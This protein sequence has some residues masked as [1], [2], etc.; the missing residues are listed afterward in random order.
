MVRTRASGCA[1]PGEGAQASRTLPRSLLLGRR[2]QGR[3]VGAVGTRKQ[4]S[5]S[6]LGPGLVPAAGPA[7]PSPREA[8]SS[9]RDRAGSESL[10]LGPESPPPPLAGA[11][12]GS[13]VV[14]CPRPP[15]TLLSQPACPQTLRSSRASTTPKPTS[16][17]SG[18]G[19]GAHRAC[20]ASS[21]P[22][23]MSGE[24]GPWNR[25]R[26]SGPGI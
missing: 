17:A 10:L 18:A 14:A 13:R 3:R 23:P 5:T 21:T 6:P 7:S 8:A 12:S 9:P 26:T 24:C 22:S 20:P 2:R 4:A 1:F 11:G 16:P 19:R 15:V 25:G